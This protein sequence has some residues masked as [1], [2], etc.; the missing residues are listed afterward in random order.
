KRLA[1]L[2]GERSLLETRLADPAL[3]AATDSALLQDLLK[4]QGALV[5]EIDALETRWLQLE[6]ALEA[7]GDAPGATNM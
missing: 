2:T 4:R 1:T 6:D 3:Y 7:L 5:Q